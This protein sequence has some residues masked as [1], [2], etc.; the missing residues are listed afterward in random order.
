MGSV[1][2]WNSKFKQTY[3]VLVQARSLERS[4]GGFELTIEARYND[5]CN[6]AITLEASP[7]TNAPVTIGQTIEG[8]PNPFIC[9]GITNQSPSVYYRVRGTGEELAIV[10]REVDFNARISVLVGECTTVEISRG[11]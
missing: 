8:N 3:Y 10:L 4:S 7:D 2:S 11:L 6:N 5:E 9:Q 1:V